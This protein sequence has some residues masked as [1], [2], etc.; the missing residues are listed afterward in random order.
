MLKDLDLQPTYES[1][2]DNILRDFYIPALSNAKIY[3]RLSAYFNV[4]SLF[5]AAEGISE[6][7][8]NNGK[9]Q[10]VLGNELPREDYES[11]R[12]GYERRANENV[13]ERLEE[14]LQGIE[15]GLFHRRMETI[16]ELVKLGRLEIKVAHRPHGGIFHKKIGI[17]TD[18]EGD[19]ISFDGSLNETYS[20]Y[21]QSRNAESIN[22]F[23]SWAGEP[24]IDYHRSHKKQFE[25]YWEDTFEHTKVLNFIDADQKSLIKILDRATLEYKIKRPEIFDL[26]EVDIFDL[27]APFAPKT[28]VIP[29]NLNGHEFKI[30]CHQSAALKSWKDNNLRGI[31]ALATG[32]GKTITSIYGLSKLFEQSENLFVVIAVP[33]QNLADQWAEILALFNVEPLLCYKRKDLWYESFQSAIFSYNNGNLDFHCSIVVNKTLL[34]ADYSNLLKTLRQDGNFLFIGDECH[35]HNTTRFKSHL[36]TNSN[37]R[38]GL[39]ATPYHYLDEEKNDNLEDFYGSIVAEYS[40]SDAITAKVLTPYEYHPVLVELTEDEVEEY[41]L[42]SLKIAQ[43]YSSENKSYAQ[44]L[45]SLLLKRSRLIG[46]A[47]NKTSALRELLSSQNPEPHS[48]FYC[49]DGWVDSEDEIDDDYSV[50]QID[51]VTLIASDFGFSPSRFTAKETLAERRRILSNFKDGSIKSLVAMKCLDEGIDVPACTTA[52]ILASSSNPRQFIQRRGRILRKSPG[53]EIAKIYDFIVYSNNPSKSDEYSEFGTSEENLM[54]TELKRIS[55]FANLARNS[56]EVYITLRP[57]LEL[58]GLTGYL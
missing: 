15:S 17:L 9:M 39:S 55:E 33:Y 11:I 49:G 54:R 31:F 26:D 32:S 56:D 52:Y 2:V 28:P 4:Q 14:E 10:L 19:S 7:L 45:N 57:V 30:M 37:Y 35:H 42:L 41:N 5:L 48:L 16:T 6:L 22:V 3:W 1:E 25:R 34:S 29:K 44:A 50:K 53:K 23:S 58:Y 18:E 24:V 40:L 38:M 47:E 8:R 13:F 20:G 21:V 12:L 36:P 27:E 51:A 43:I 46:S